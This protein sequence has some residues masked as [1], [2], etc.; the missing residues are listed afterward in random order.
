MDLCCLFLSSGVLVPLFGLHNILSAF[1]H[2]DKESP[3]RIM[4]EMLSAITISF[5]VKTK[6]ALVTF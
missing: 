3:W 6:K 5:Q 1:K 4:I 2:D